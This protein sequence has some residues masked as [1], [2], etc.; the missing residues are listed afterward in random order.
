MCRILTI[1][2]LFVGICRAN[3]QLNEFYF[4]DTAGQEFGTTVVTKQHGSTFIIGGS[5]FDRYPGQPSIVTTDLDGNVL[6]TTTTADS[7][8]TRGGVVYKLTIAGEY[9]YAVCAVRYANEVWKVAIATGEILWKVKI[10]SSNDVGFF[11]DYDASSLLLSH[12][13]TYDGTVYSASIVLLNKATGSTTNLIDRGNASWAA[14]YY[15]V[16]ID[17][18]KNIYYT[19][20][21]SIYRYDAK[22]KTIS[23]RTKVLTTNILDYQYIHV[24]GSGKIFVFGTKESGFQSGRV[25]A[26]DKKTGTLLWEAVATRVDTD[27]RLEKVIDDGTHLISTWRNIYS[28]GGSYYAWTTKINK[29]TGEVV[30]AATPNFGDSK[31]QNALDLIVDEEKNVLL[32]G[33]HSATNYGPGA[34]SFFKLDG[35]SGGTEYYKTISNNGSVTDKLS[36]GFGIHSIN[37]AIYLIG[38][39]ETSHYNGKQRATPAIVK[40]NA[41][42]GT[43]ISIKYLFGTYRQPSRLIA[44][45]KYGSQTVQLRQVGRR[46]VVGLYS[47][48]NAVWEQI[49]T[50]EYA[51]IAN[52]LTVSPE[53]IVTATG[54]SRE[55][56]GEAPSYYDDYRSDSIITATFNIDGSQLQRKGFPI[57]DGCIPIQTI[58]DGSATFVVYTTGSRFFLRKIENGIISAEVALDLTSGFS[59]VS[60]ATSNIIIPYSATEFIIGGPR[61]SVGIVL[62]KINKSSL[63]ISA[64]PIPPTLLTELRFMKRIGNQSILIA[65]RKPSGRECLMRF[66]LSTNSVTWV[67]EPFTYNAGITRF[68]YD[69]VLRSVFTMGVSENKLLIQRVNA[70]SGNTDWIYVHDPADIKVVPFDIDIDHQLQKVI[71]AG[72]EQHVLSPT[73]PDRIFALRTDF[74]G[75][76]YHI[77]RKQTTFKKYNRARVVQVMGDGNVLIGGEINRHNTSEGFIYTDKIDACESFG[78]VAEPDNGVIKPSIDGD[79]YAWYDCNSNQMVSSEKLLHPTYSGQFQ[80]SV[81]KQGC[82]VVSECIMFTECPLTLTG[83]I[84]VSGNQLIA[85]DNDAS[86]QWIDCYTNEIIPGA[87]NQIFIPG[88]SGQ[89]RVALSKN[90]CSTTSYCLEFESIVTGLPPQ[91][92]QQFRLFPNPAPHGACVMV[93]NVS[94]ATSVTILNLNGVVVHKVMLDNS[95]IETKLAVSD[96]APGM[97]IVMIEYLSGRHSNAKLMIH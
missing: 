24:D 86:Y 19:K 3:A 25:H 28:G 31:E 73:T 8:E 88:I 62:L 32:T 95:G 38:N 65:G 17:S 94:S 13:P 61:T 14:A 55:F 39:L 78:V 60:L 40:V 42:D 59:D 81:L 70:S 21:D 83:L 27:V 48:N 52:G 79:E 33:Y 56:G 85:E 45:E 53:G 71:V 26:F 97:Y 77:L 54:T 10:R 57:N 58:R 92:D 89:F 34:W 43:V 63:A 50:S 15:G 46:G 44:I 5:S 12:E 23:W 68:V 36:S 9:L 11:E 29:T 16:A 75:N 6:W 72:Y 90:G 7:M 66:E 1:V 64:V 49:L 47:G 2:L 96:L 30:W 82:K 41:V 67:K 22:T 4:S 87:N 93:E 74:S 76:L 84:S 69:D 80:V 91:E 20:T 51:F 35:N 37:G 18:E